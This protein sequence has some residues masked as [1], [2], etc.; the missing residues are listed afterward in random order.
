[1]YFKG[2]EPAFKSVR[3]DKVRT[4]TKGE[5]VVI[6]RMMSGDHIGEYNGIPPSNK[7]FEMPTVHLFDFRDGKITAWNQYMNTKILLDLSNK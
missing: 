3:F 6:E 5:T 4:I 1:M 7:K 2:M